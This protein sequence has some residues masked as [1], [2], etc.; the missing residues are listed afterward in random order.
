MSA[1]RRLL[2]AL[3]AAGLLGPAATA[4]A[5][6]VVQSMVVGRGGQ[7]LSAARS[8]AATATSVTVAGRT[9]SIAAATPLAVLADLRAGGGPGFALRDYGH[10]GGASTASSSQLFVYSLGGEANRGQDG[11]EYKVGGAAGSTGAA[12]PS[13]VSGN[14]R[15]VQ[16][17][18]RVLW[19]WCEAT[20][21]GCE[22]TLEVSAT[23]GAVHG[24]PLTAA[25]YGYDNNGRGSPVAG[26]VVTLGSGR[27]VTGPHGRATLTA[28]SA[29]G[30]YRLTATRAGM[31]PS[32]PVTI[33]VG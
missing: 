2:A 15:L 13:G 7:V 23:G 5:A 11:W 26:A 10:C 27:A 32:F 28:P 22:R 1:E 8:I 16:S 9:C 33:A 4:A 31:V 29:R 14:G 17:G 19:F 12:D 30:R 25:V 18:E 21:S 6:P 3:L 20:A 24:K